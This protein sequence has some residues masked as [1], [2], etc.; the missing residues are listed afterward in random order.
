MRTVQR[1]LN[2]RRHCRETG[3][4]E[5]Q[6]PRGRTQDAERETFVVDVVRAKEHQKEAKAGEKKTSA[7][8]QRMAE[9]G[10]GWRFAAAVSHAFQSNSNLLSTHTY[11]PTHNNTH[12]KSEA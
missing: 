3:E 4:S 1:Y 11:A 5:A 8:A 10:Q 6:E 7:E 2:C 9:C 12:K